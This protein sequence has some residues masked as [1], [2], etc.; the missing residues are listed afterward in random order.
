VPYLLHSGRTQLTK[1]PRVEIQKDLHASEMD[2]EEKEKEIG[3]GE[4]APVGGGR[5]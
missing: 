5:K 4:N 3:V 1:V 2:M